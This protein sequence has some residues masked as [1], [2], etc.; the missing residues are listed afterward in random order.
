MSFLSSDPAGF[1]W[2]STPV[3]NSF[4]IEYMPQAPSDYVKVYL[5]GLCHCHSG[6]NSDALS[7]ERLAKELD[8]EESAVTCAFQYWER[9]RLVTRIKDKPPQYCYLSAVKALMGKQLA[10]QDEG[11]QEFGQALYAIFGDKR[12]LHGNE[13]QLAYEWVEQLGLPREI[14]LMLVE[15]MSSTRGTQFSFKEAQ[16]VAV[17]LAEKKIVTIEAAEQLF[18]RSEAAWK[19]AGKVLRRMSKFRSPTMDELDLFLKWTK[20]WGFTP[21]SVEG[22]CAELTRGDPSFAYLDAVL[23]RLY[24]KNEGKP[25]KDAAKLLEKEKEQRAPVKEMLTAFDTSMAVTDG[26][27]ALYEEMRKYATHEVILVAAATASK[28]RQK[29]VDEVL[30]LVMS[31]QEKGLTSADEVKAYIAS[32]KELSK[33]LKAIYDIAGD[34][35][36][37]G[38][39]D[40]AVLTRWREWG[41]K[42]ELVDYAASCARGAKAKLPYMDKL[43]SDWREK[44]L[45]TVEQAKKE[46]EQ[47]QKA[48]KDKPAS[49]KPGKIVTEQRYEQRDYSGAEYQGPSAELLEEAKQYDP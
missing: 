8:M 11:Y 10:P 30:E 22:A 38:Q 28:K 6:E 46:R 5:Y 33:A 20:E 39:A 45:V 1:L 18:S 24:E 15:H 13:T 44:G 47:H 41:I 37:L 26:I 9:C 31:W 25:V 34:T 21:K 16:K 48:L 7:I 23:K 36:S 2:D 40:R 27:T 12:K 17:E 19:G 49:S 42:Q 3:P 32:T 43:I 35:G 14:V 29:S 4:L